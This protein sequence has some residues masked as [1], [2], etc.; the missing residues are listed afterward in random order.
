MTID[1]F[2]KHI[3][4]TILKRG[5]S[6]FDD[7]LVGE[8]EE[9]DNCWTAEVYGSEDYLV[10]ITLDD[11]GEIRDYSCDCPYDG[12]LC[13][14]VAAMCYAIREEKAQILKETSTN[15]SAK[16]KKNMFENLL[17]KINL[18]EYKDF[19]RHQSKQD[20]NFKLQF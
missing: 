11:R 2:E 9:G 19:I 13:K 14:H 1:N 4:P 18:N 17:D 3:N 15:S 20:K 5:R 7:G 12:A 10:D 16:S 6:Y 8:L